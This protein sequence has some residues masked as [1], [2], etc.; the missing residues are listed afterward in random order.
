[1]PSKLPAKPRRTWLRPTS[2][3][4]RG[5][6]FGLLAGG[7][8]AWLLSPPPSRRRSLRVE[9]EAWRH[10]ATLYSLN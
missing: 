6:A 5:L 3:F 4:L 1:M 10:L 8:V 7:I 9:P 2:R